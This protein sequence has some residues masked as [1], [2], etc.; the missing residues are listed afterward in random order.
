MKLLFPGNKGQRKRLKFFQ[1]Q[2][3]FGS[4]CFDLWTLNKKNWKLLMAHKSLHTKPILKAKI[5]KKIK[6]SDFL[7]QIKFE[8]K[9]CKLDF[10]SEVKFCKSFECKQ[11]WKVISNVQSFSAQFIWQQTLINS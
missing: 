2:N 10:K 9:G 11:H 7:E 4:H 8:N 3:L 5:I 6:N 1:I